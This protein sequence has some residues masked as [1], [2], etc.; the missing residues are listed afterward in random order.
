MSISKLKISI[1]CNRYKY[2][3]QYEHS[4]HISKLYGL[5]V[6]QKLLIKSKMICKRNKYDYEKIAE[7]YKNK[8]NELKNSL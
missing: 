3:K 7:Y 1:A 2:G 8:C 5:E 4:L 6:P